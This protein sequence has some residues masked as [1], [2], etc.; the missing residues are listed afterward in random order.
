[1]VNGEK[2]K[3]FFVFQKKSCFRL[4]SLTAV[5]ADLIDDT[6]LFCF[7]GFAGLT[8]WIYFNCFK[9]EIYYDS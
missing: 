7:S 8:D 2:Y 9:P 4:Y 1:M 3:V 6:L 5:V